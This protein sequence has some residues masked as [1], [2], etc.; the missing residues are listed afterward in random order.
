MTRRRAPLLMGALLLLAC[1]PL[2]VDPPEPPPPPPS[3]LTITLDTTDAAF[4]PAGRKVTLSA[5]VTGATPDEV[6]LYADTL[7]VKT[8]SAPY[9]YTLNCDTYQEGRF[10]FWMKATLGDQSFVSLSRTVTVDRT[11]PQIN[12]LNPQTRFPSMNEPLEFVFSEAMDPKS[13]QGAP[14]RVLDENGT[15]V[16]SQV[17]LSQDGL[18]LRLIPNAPLALPKT[19]TPELPPLML[20]DRAGNPLPANA[21]IPQS[22]T[23]WPFTRAGAALSGEMIEEADFALDHWKTRRVLT[24][25]ETHAWRD[26]PRLVVARWTEAGWKELP[27]PRQ[28]DEDSKAP[29]SPR[30]AMDRTGRIVLAW[31]EGAPDAFVYVKRYDGTSWQSLGTPSSVKGGEVSGLVMTLESD[32]DPVLAWADQNDTINVARWEHTGWNTLGGPFEA[33]PGPGTPAR[34]PAIAAEADQV[35]VAWSE[36]PIGQDQPHVIVWEYLNHGWAP[37]GIPLLVDATSGC[38]ATGIALVLKNS[39]P[40]VAWTEEPEKSLRSAIYFSRME[41]SIG[42]TPPEA[43]LK[44]TEGYS[45]SAPRLVLGTDE[46]PWVAWQRQDG[47]SISEHIL[48]RKRSESGWGPEQVAIGGGLVNFQLDAQDIP[49]V[50]VRRRVPPEGLMLTRPQ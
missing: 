12:N 21:W 30:V 25:T 5:T 46:A 36:I 14:I 32:G 11:P 18:H 50:A 27:T 49:W 31:A 26:Q 42:W 40:L 17:S 10:S 33:N 1:E 37:V 15:P 20:T 19:L 23:Y 22:V 8:L 34:F 3:E 6:S 7:P 4:C 41:P 9:S 16:P 48:Y 35:M 43:V 24:W 2:R 29:F 47:P 38:S 39:L 13:L 44:P 28:E 45:A